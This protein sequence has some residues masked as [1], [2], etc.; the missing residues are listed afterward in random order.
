[1]LEELLRKLPEPTIPQTPRESPQPM[2][3]EEKPQSL[4]IHGLPKVVEPEQKSITPY[5]LPR[6]KFPST[7]PVFRDRLKRAIEWVIKDYLSEHMLKFTIPEYVEHI[8]KVFRDQQKQPYDYELLVKTLANV[9]K[10]N[11][12]EKGYSRLVKDVLKTAAKLTPG[13]DPDKL[14]EDFTKMLTL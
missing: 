7:N 12:I 1:M 6:V 11:K 2:V 10:E 5:D 8:M 3:P 14:Y 9:I 4:P 13:V